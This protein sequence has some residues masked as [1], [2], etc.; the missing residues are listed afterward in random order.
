MPELLSLPAELLLHIFDDLYLHRSRIMLPHALLA[1]TPESD[2][3]YRAAYQTLAALA[4]TC[5]FL[6]PIATEALYK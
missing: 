4:R 3:D 6:R 2:C 1:L 5:Q